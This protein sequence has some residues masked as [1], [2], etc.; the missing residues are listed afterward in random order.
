[1][2][3]E[4]FMW[5][6]G[7]DSNILKNTVLNNMSLGNELNRSLM[8][9]FRIY[10]AVGGM[11]QAVDKYI[12]TNNLIEVDRVKKEIINLYMDDIKKIDP[13]GRTSAM[14][15]SIPSQLA[16][17]KNRFVTSYATGKKVN[18][19]DKE[20]LF[21]L[22]DSKMVLPCYNIKNPGP[23]LSLSVDLDY[24]KLYL[25]DIGLFV[26]MMFNTNKKNEI[27]NK[28]LSDKLSADLGYL[29]ENVIAQIINSLNIPLYFHSW[30]KENSTHKYE[31]DFLVQNGAKFIPIEVKSSYINNHSSLDAFSSKYSKFIYRKILFSQKDFYHIKDLELKPIYSALFILNDLYKD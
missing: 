3:F 5:A 20:R 4:E 11:P 29:Y 12:K 1:M 16:L 26:T 10:M 6:I 24:F 19:K 18:E 15:N 21:D 31:I 27:Y 9:K 17:K 25:S 2:D 8:R 13:S 14:Y 28:L 30:N 22:I 7:E 23:S